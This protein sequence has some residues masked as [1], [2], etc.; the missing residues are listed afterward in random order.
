MIKKEYIR[1]KVCD[2]IPYERNPRKIPQEA[3]DDVRESIRQ[4]GQMN[5]IEIDEENVILAGHTRRLA[6]LAEGVE[7][8]DAIRYTG[9][10]AEQKRKYRILSNKTGE[11]TGWDFELLDV[12]LDGL[13]FDGYDFGFDIADGDLDIDGL[14]TDAEH[15]EK[16]AKTVVC[17]NCGEEFELE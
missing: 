16:K 8:V 4:C 11:K 6:Y 3:I 2:L 17:P 14:F 9:M 13:D 12:E 5:P 15:K 1:I 7:E 10:T